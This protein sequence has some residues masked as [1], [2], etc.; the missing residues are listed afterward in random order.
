VQTT[1]SRNWTDSNSNFF[2]D[3]DL[4]NPAAQDLRATGGDVC[5]AWLN[6]NFGNFIPATF[7]DPAVLSGWGV[8]PWNWEF[9][10]SVQHEIVPRV[11][12]NAGWYRRIMGNFM[13]LDNEA[14]SASDFLP[15][16]VTVPSDSRLPNAG[17]TLTGI[18]DQRAVVLNRN[19]VKSADQFGTQYQHWNGF[20]ISIDARVGNGI[21]FQGGISSGKAVSDNCEIVKTVPEALQFPVALPAGVT[22][23][24]SNGAYVGA[25]GIGAGAWTPLDF[26][27]QESPFLTGGKALGSYQESPFL[28]G[29]KALGSYQLPWGGVRLSATY[30][31]LPGPQVGANVIYTNA[32]IAAGRVQGL[33]RAAFLANQAT[34][35]VLQPGTL[36]GDRL[37][38]VDFRATKIF[39]VGKGRLE[40]DF[41]VYNLGNSDAI[42]TQINTFGATWQRPSSI[43]QPRFVKFTAR[44]DF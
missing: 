34:V 41:D 14:L 5:G 32:D 28:T 20:D 15:F 36:Y 24:V 21:F 38:Q 18:Y 27:H 10:T 19:V 22:S 6:I 13:V 2:P 3:C 40:A 16:S 23:P 8:R 39:K 31:S 7:Y 33:G 17:G 12:V 11:S 43:I 30:Q 35:N 1:T 25:G 4:L 42:L 26:C 29:G 44:Y 37:N 9:S